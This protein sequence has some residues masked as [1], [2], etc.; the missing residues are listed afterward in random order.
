MT[1]SLK[2]EGNLQSWQIQLSSHLSLITPQSLLVF[3]KF[4]GQVRRRSE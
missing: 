2:W 1:N 3:L 4:E